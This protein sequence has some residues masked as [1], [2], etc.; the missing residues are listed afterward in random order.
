MGSRT[1]KAIQTAGPP[2]GRAPTNH[3]CFSPFFPDTLP[4]PFLLHPFS[5]HSCQERGT[6]PE[7]QHFLASVFPEAG[8]PVPTDTRTP[9]SQ[10]WTRE[11][12]R[13]SLPLPPTPSRHVDAPQGL[14][15]ALPRGRSWPRA[16]QGRDMNTLHA[17]HA[18][19]RRPPLTHSGCSCLHLGGT[20]LSG[21]TG[22]AA[23]VQATSPTRCQPASPRAADMA[24]LDASD[25][26]ASH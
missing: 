10:P 22:K 7:R 2:N 17:L 5:S 3:F 20:T 8:P 13:S 15:A 1:L 24:P 4:S 11:A 25:P 16:P 9:P 23:P 18:R 21:T 6:A 14:Q 19:L 12:A 26:T